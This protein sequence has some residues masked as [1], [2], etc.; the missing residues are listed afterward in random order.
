[1]EVEPQRMIAERATLGGVTSWTIHNELDRLETLMPLCRLKSPL[2][3]L[4]LGTKSPTISKTEPRFVGTE[5]ST[6]NVA[7]ENITSICMST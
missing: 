7:M 3:T 4:N 2:L 6:R 1:V 5:L